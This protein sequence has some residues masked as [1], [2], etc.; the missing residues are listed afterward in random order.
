MG[1]RKDPFGLPLPSICEA[2]TLTGI[3]GCG[4]Y[5]NYKNA[6]LIIF[7]LICLMNG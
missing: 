5:H 6:N 2:I 1:M 4:E 7:A 3:N